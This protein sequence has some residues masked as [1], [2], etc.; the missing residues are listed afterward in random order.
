MP[1]LNGAGACKEIRNW[2]A[3]TGNHRTPILGFSATVQG[4]GDCKAAGMDAFVTKIQRTPLLQTIMHSLGLGLPDV[5]AELPVFKP[6]KTVAI[7][8]IDN[9]VGIQNFSTQTDFDS[10]L[11]VRDISFFVLFY[12]SITNSLRL[13]LLC[14][15]HCVCLTS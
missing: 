7:S 6:A 2:E 12:F 1:K 11:E 9:E 13:N 8:P 3:E 10:A 14:P 4:E 15:L 5:D